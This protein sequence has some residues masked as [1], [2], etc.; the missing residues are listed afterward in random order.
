MIL[1][2]TS[3]PELQLVINKIPHSLSLIEVSTVM[4]A[5]FTQGQ[6]I[7]SIELPA[8]QCDYHFTAFHFEVFERLVRPEGVAEIRIDEINLYLAN[9]LSILN[10][11]MPL[12]ET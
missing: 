9:S 2:G 4:V 7:F 5:I 3:R 6:G 10:G 12:A 8:A 11:F 1:S